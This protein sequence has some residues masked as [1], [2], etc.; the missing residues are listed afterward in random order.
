MKAALLLL[1][2]AAGA[3]AFSTASLSLLLNAPGSRT[4][5]RDLGRSAAPCSLKMKKAPEASGIKGVPL[6]L[7]RRTAAWILAGS[8]MGAFRAYAEEP[9]ASPAATPE[10]GSGICDKM[11]GCKIEGPLTPPKRVFKDIFEEVRAGINLQ[12]HVRGRRAW[13]RASPLYGW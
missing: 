9:A 13:I 3:E 8:T 12:Q 4:S 1:W 2:C 5:R 11:M 10:A 6:L 7:N